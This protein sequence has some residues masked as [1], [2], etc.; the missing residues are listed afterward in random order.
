MS[1]DSES[2]SRPTWERHIQTGLLTFIVLGVG[3]VGNHMGSLRTDT[4]GM[5]VQVAE[6]GVKINGL[7]DR[8]DRLAA[9]RYT[10]SQ[11]ARDRI[12]IMD[13]I[14]TLNSDIRETKSRLNEL[15]RSV[16]EIQSEL[17]RDGN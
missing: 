8:F 4:Q 17:N 10:G 12:E 16:N 11:A 14:G 15:E 13:R 3:V 6:Q 5:A 1:D 7:S 2:N 9:D